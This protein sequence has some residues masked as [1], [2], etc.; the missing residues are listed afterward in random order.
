MYVLN[1]EVFPRRWHP[2]EESSV[3]P[4][5][6]GAFVRTAHT[7]SDY[8]GI[9]LGD[10]F[11]DL[12]LP[13]RKRSVDIFQVVDQHLSTASDGFSAGLPIPEVML[14][15][16][17]EEFRSLSPLAAIDEIKPTPYNFPIPVG[18]GRLAERAD[19]H[20][21]SHQGDGNQHSLDVSLHCKP[22]T[23]ASSP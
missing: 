7:A 14:H 6:L 8:D 5:L 2:D 9:A 19:R 3:D 15:V 1:D 22:P 21:D 12:H 16:R 20:S 11:N 4:P 10:H 23:F 18:L 17:S 13:V